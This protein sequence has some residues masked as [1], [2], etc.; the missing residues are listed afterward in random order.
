MA[1][2]SCSLNVHCIFSTKERAPMLNR[3]KGKLR[4]GRISSEAIWS[5][6]SLKMW[7]SSTGLPGKSPVSRARTMT[8]SACA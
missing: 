3:E 2:T 7:S 5:P 1:N 6:A 4:H 8:S